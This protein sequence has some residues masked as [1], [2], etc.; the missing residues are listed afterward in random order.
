MLIH[1]LWAA[2]AVFAIHRFAAV[3]DAF[4][5]KAVES[6]LPPPPVE[7]PEDLVAVANQERESWAQE[8]M[9]R[10]IRERYEDLKDWNRVRSA[11]GVGRI[12]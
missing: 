4:A 2:V 7:I 1:L 12:E 10:V 5:P 6:T 9:L 11:F 8:E 3:A